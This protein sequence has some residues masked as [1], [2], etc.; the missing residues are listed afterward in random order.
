LRE[1][2]SPLYLREWEA[3]I[4]GTEKIFFS[5]ELCLENCWSYKISKIFFLI[6]D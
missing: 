2:R 5:L 1:E 6:E 3:I 4:W